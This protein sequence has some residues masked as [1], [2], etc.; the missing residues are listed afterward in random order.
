MLIIQQD[1]RSKDGLYNLIPEQTLPSP[2][3]SQPSTPAK[4]RFSSPVG[5]P[6]RKRK[7]AEAVDEEDE[8][9]PSSQS[10]S[11]SR[12]SSVTP[13]KRLRGQDLFDSRVFN[14]A[15]STSTFYR[16][17]ASLREKIHDEVKETSSTHKLIRV[18]RD[19]GRLM[20]CY[21]Q[22]IDGLEAREGLVMDLKRGRGTK[23]R[24]MKKHWAE[25]RKEHPQ[26]TDHD[27][28][29]EVVQLHGDLETLRCSVCAT[30]WTW[31]ENET[32]VFMDGFAPRCGKCATKSDDRQ[33]T[34]KRGLAVGSLR[35]NIV[36]YGEDHP[37][38]TLLSPFVPFDASSQPDV[39]IIMGT[40]L[41][42]FGLQKIIREFAK[43]VHAQKNGKVIFVN[44]TKPAES[45]WDSFIDYFV[46]MDC[47]DWVEDLRTRRPDLWLRQGELALTVTKKPSVKRK[48][49]SDASGEDGKEIRPKKL[50]KLPVIEVSSKQP[51][52]QTVAPLAS[53]IPRVA[54]APLTPRRHLNVESF[55]QKL[56]SPRAQRKRPDLSPITENLLPQTPHGPKAVLGFPDSPNRPT[57]SPFTPMLLGGSN[58][59]QEVKASED[60]DIEIPESDEEKENRARMLSNEINEDSK[61]IPG[62]PSRAA[63]SD[64]IILPLG[65]RSRKSPPGTRSRIQTWRESEKT[66]TSG[67]SGALS[68]FAAVISGRS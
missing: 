35:P 60:K 57:F 9:L 38:N 42:V 6:S 44:R 1:F 21:T 24:F 59:R 29:C 32:E 45:V 18:L 46:P 36:L 14:S 40:S 5:T 22:N 47:D 34:G 8:E 58:L 7:A 66:M 62:T 26:G 16:F 13:S 53:A 27:G 49:V 56:L 68:R 65:L 39:L 33:K 67:I 19:G 28:G 20:R 10:S 54:V 4:P 31:T 48:R 11:S 37:Q 12:R 43:A 64:K 61:S 15:D 50:T 2:P 51:N 63:R 30:Q 23:R 17:I 55:R 41:K 25:P 3:P 52:E